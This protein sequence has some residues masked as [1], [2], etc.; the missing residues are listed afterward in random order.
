M[1]KRF[2]MAAAVVV[3]VS[4]FFSGCSSN[5][6]PTELDILIEQLQTVQ[7]TSETVPE[8]IIEEETDKADEPTVSETTENTLQEETT[9]ENS[10][11]TE[12]SSED[13]TSP[14]NMEASSEDTTSPDNT[15]DTSD[16][17]EGN[18]NDPVTYKS[19][20]VTVISVEEDHI[21]VELDGVV[22]KAIIDE[23]TS[24][25]GGEILK[26]KT[27]TITY[28]LNDDDSEA[29]IAAAAITVLP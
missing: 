25:F 29:S 12:V 14:D 21:M 23:S 17:T 8:E 15:E 2:S 4:L 22:Y 18:A 27:V 16:I 1:N 24:I 19:L 28:V 11:N 26:D 3:T 9:P 20:T 6:S 13:T 5:D 10:E 7:L